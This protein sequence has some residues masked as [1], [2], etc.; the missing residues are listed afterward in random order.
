MPA[1]ASVANSTS[2]AVVSQSLSG[3]S[4]ASGSGSFAAA[5]AGEAA[6]S[7]ASERLAEFEAWK[8]GYLKKGISEDHRQDVEESAETYRQVL[9]KASAKGGYDDPQAFLKTLSATELTAVQHIH[10][11]AEPIDPASLDKEGA[12]NLLYAPGQG[13]DID[14][15]GFLSVGEAKTWQFPPT[16]APDSV[17]QAWNKATQGMSDKDVLLLQG[18]FLGAT[19][20]AA[21]GQGSAYL[22]ADADYAGLTGGILDAARLAAMTAPAWQQES[23]ATEIRALERF[24]SC[25]GGAA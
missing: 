23:R 5:L 18:A 1:I 20:P 16:D 7:A 6:T 22:G 8:R 3:R 10:C 2:S 21:M 19:L 9:E 14:R 24:L 11:L 17:K 12:L 25:L 13:K 15:D 4:G